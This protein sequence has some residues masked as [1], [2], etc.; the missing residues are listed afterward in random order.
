MG[1]KVRTLVKATK[2]YRLILDIKYPFDLLE[3]SYVPSLFRNLVLLSKFNVIGYYLN[4]GNKCFSLFKN[5]H[6]IEIGIGICIIS[7]GLYA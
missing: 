7:Y 5:N 1:N 2:T 6:L 3:T 4:F